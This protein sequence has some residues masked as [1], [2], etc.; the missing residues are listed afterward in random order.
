M[1]KTCMV[2]I[3]ALLA[4][5]CGGSGGSSG[6]GGTPK[7]RAPVTA[8]D[9]CM[10]FYRSSWGITTK[11]RRLLDAFVLTIRDGHGS[12]GD[13]EIIEGFIAQA[14]GGGHFCD[15]SSMIET[16]ED[17]IEFLRDALMLLY[18]VPMLNETVAQDDYI[19]LADRINAYLEG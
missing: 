14:D 11:H 5:S 19:E 4:A 16:P 2:A 10:A 13:A 9:H 7:E 12:V 1:I 3:M 6:S 15:P 8:R 18:T 17:G